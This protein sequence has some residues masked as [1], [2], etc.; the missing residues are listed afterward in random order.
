MHQTS[1]DAFESVKPILNDLQ[2]RVLDCV[3][4]LGATGLT[5]EELE[6][7]FRGYKPSSSRTR[8]SELVR[9]GMVVDS[10]RTR[11][12]SSGR[13]MIVWV[14]TLQQTELF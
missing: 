2:R 8:I 3:Q 4:K 13:K 9:L 12:S 7:Y 10:G 5:S 6:T 1:R 14:A 11:P